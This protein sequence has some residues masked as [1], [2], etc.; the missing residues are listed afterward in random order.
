MGIQVPLMIVDFSLITVMTGVFSDHR[1]T[2]LR[3]QCYWRTFQNYRSY[4]TIKEAAPEKFR[5]DPKEFRSEL[6]GVPDHREME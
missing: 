5:V 4:R 3:A 1:V 2:H 6:E